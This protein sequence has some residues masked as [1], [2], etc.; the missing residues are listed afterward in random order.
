MNYYD[1]M[2]SFKKML[3]DALNNAVTLEEMD[4]L[5]DENFTLSFMGQTCTIC[6]GATEYYSILEMLENILE[7]M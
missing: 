3:E 6:F 7:E 5:Y 1:K 4:K 2:M